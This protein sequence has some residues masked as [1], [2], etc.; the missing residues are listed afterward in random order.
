LCAVQFKSIDIAQQLLTGTFVPTVEQN[1]PS[2]RNHNR[3]DLI[4]SAKERHVICGP[5]I[6][7]MPHAKLCLGV[8][9]IIWTE[10]FDNTELSWES[11]PLVT[12]NFGFEA[13]GYTGCDSIG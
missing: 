7:V 10:R 3:T 13:I 9:L 4:D 12:L 5:Q 2:V 1:K 11:I 6:L 8:I